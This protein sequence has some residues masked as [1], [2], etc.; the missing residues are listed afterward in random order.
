MVSRVSVQIL[1][2]NV[3]GKSCMFCNTTDS[4]F[5]PVTSDHDVIGLTSSEVMQQFLDALTEDPRSIVDL[6][7][8][9]NEWFAATFDEGD[10]GNYRRKTN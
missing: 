1:T 8:V 7:H 10:D 2:D 6:E 9:Y 3:E 5:G 4:A